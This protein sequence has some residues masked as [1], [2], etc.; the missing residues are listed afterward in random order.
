MSKALVTFAGF[1]SELA[2]R[3]DEISSIL[4]PHISI[5][6]FRN[7][8]I[9]ACKQEPRLLTVE[10]RSLHQA[11]TEAAE[12]GLHPDGRE[13]AIVIFGN[14]AQWTPMLYGLRKRAMELAGM[15][16]SAEVVHEGDHFVWHQGDD[17]RLEHVPAKLGTDRGQ[18]I[19]AYAIFRKDG[20]IIHR[21]VMDRTQIEAVRNTNRKW[22]SSIMWTKFA[23]EAWRKTVVRRAV[24]TVPCVPELERIIERE[25]RQFAFAP[26]RSK[27]ER[28]EAAVPPHDSDGVI[29]DVEDIADDGSEMIIEQP[30]AKPVKKPSAPASPLERLSAACKAA[31]SIT[32]INAAWA[33]HEK[34]IAPADHDKAVAIFE[35]AFERVVGGRN[36]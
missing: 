1:E 2:Q 34:E 29:I 20:A 6:R 5:D 23:G 16:L 9:I 30:S 27:P 4:P 35:V 12:D 11:I 33:D 31:T 18:M 28:K 36:G 32:E 7:T 22:S 8:A 19:G 24:K 25:D 26:A 10:R 15:I 13:G 21:E 14:E 3:Q 17:P